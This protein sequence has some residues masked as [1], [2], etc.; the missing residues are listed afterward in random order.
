MDLLAS[1]I[2]NIMQIKVAV[3]TAYCP[4]M[5]L[6]AISNWDTMGTVERMEAEKV[7]SIVHEPVIET[8]QKR[9]IQFQAV[10]HGVL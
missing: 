5:G 10:N 3:S 8:H 9:S 1:D 2:N 7:L 6:S 4:V